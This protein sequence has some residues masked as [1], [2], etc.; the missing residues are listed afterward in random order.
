MNITHQALA[1]LLAGCSHQVIDADPCT[2]PEPFELRDD[3][4][5]EP[6][7]KADE[8]GPCVVGFICGP[9]SIE[10]IY[11]DDLACEEHLACL[12]EQEGP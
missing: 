2:E 8:R 11:R 1:L 5:L 9:T 3:C 12:A 4:R 6:A 7:C 10:C